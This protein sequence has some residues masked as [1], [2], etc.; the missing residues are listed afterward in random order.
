MGGTPLKQVVDEEARVSVNNRKLMCLLKVS[1]AS[2]LRYLA[3]EEM[4]YYSQN[5]SFLFLL[6]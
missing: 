2:T 1:D 4:L 3:V 6:V 5:E